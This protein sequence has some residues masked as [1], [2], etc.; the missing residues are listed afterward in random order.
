MTITLTREEAQQ[1]LDALNNYVG[2]VV[3]VNDPDSWTKVEDGGEP[4]RKAIKTLCE[5][6]KHP[7]PVQVLPHEFV[8]AGDQQVLAALEW[9]LPVI[10]D[11]GNKE[12]LHKHHKAIETLRARLAQPEQE[13]VWVEVT[14]NTGDK[15]IL[16]SAVE[17]DKIRAARDAGLSVVPL[18]TAPP[19]REWQGLTDEEIRKIVGVTS[20]DS[21]WNVTIVH[22]W[23]RAI[24]AKLK[25]KNNG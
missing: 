14:T 12:Q 8:R 21:D 5:K 11:F 24:E 20:A 3:S 22:K 13:P 9:N 18:Y 15:F 1:V 23:I 4:A 25:E 2:V 19:Q 10:E 7:Q 16:D 6:L 17:A